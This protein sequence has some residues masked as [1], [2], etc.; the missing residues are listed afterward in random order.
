[1]VRG[2]DL[3]SSSPRQAYLGAV[4][5]HPTPLYAHVPLVLNAAGKRLAKRDGAVTLSDIGR[6]ASL[7][8]IA[9]SLGFAA[10]TLVGML[11]EFDPALLP[12]QPWIYEPVTP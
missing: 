7:T 9:T 5:G 2:D 1:M 8:Q 4:L 12:H 10:E 3:L 11:A 6:D